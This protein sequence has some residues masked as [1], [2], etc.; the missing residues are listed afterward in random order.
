MMDEERCIECD[1]IL[2]ASG[3]KSNYQ[4]QPYQGYCGMCVRKI[5]SGELKMIKR[6]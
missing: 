4:H 2:H 1:R 5:K 6:D 3:S